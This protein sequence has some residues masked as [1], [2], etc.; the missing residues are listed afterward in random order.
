MPSV[1]QQQHV[2]GAGSPSAQMAS[3]FPIYQAERA[4]DQQEDAPAAGSQLPDFS[5]FDHAAFAHLQG[6]VQQQRRSQAQ[7]GGWAAAAAQHFASSS[8]SEDEEAAPALPAEPPGGRAG[9]RV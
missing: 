6:Q 1:G 5:S 4:A 2:R 3:L 7:E 9:R 8:S